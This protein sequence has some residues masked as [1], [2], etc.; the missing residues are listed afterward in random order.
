[1]VLLPRFASTPFRLLATPQCLQNALEDEYKAMSFEPV[2]EDARLDPSFEAEVISGISSV[3]SKTP[4]LRYSPMSA[5]LMT[6]AYDQLT[7]LMEQWVGQPLERSWGY[8]V[9]SYGPGSWLHMHR[10]RVDTHVVSCIVHVADQ[11][12][13]PWP[14]DF[15]DHEAVHHRVLFKPGSMLFYE[16]LCPHGRASEFEGEFYRNMYFHW[17]PKDWDPAP[18]QQLESKFSSVEMACLSNQALKKIALIPETWREW[19]I[20]NRDRGCDREG[21]IERAMAHGFERDSLEAVLNSVSTAYALSPV[22]ELPPAEARPEM[23][24]VPM[25][26]KS[27]NTDHPSMLQ[28]FQAPLTSQQH[29]P[30]A[31][32]LDTPLAQIYEIPD[33]LGWEEC[34][35]VIEAIDQGLQ[36]STVTRGS[37]DYR[38]SRTCHLRQKHAALAEELDRRFAALLGVDPRLSEPIQGQRYDP[39]EYFKEHTDWFAPHSKEFEEHSAKGGQRT[40]TVMVYLN[41]VERGGKTCFKHLD[42]CFTPVKGLA[43]AWNNLQADGTPNP[44]T[45]H[46]SIPVEAGS[47]WVITKWFRAQMGRNG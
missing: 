17:R 39:G 42:R 32:K 27:A 10:D 9:R 23:R 5:E 47:K 34:Q 43:L 29:R 31:W 15:I 22:A 13:Q 20:L 11:S 2:Q 7:P 18:Y 30:R 44:L 3:R 21:I 37:S 35:R 36:P 33:F 12:N 14:L 25:Q 40:W 6:L 38:T 16:S 28:W 26:A 19:L 1:M 45:L 41:A 46:E 4:D 24:V 8:G